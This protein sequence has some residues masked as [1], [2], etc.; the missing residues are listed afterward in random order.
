P[1]LSQ[2]VTAHMQSHLAGE[3][4]VNLDDPGDVHEVFA[5]LE[6]RRAEGIEVWP[7]LQPLCV[8]VAHHRYTASRGRDYVIILTEDLKKSLGKRPR[9]FRT[10]RVRHGLAAAC[11]LFGKVDIDAQTSQHSQSRKPDLRVHLIDVTRDEETHFGHRT[12]VTMNGVN[13][14]SASPNSC[15]QLRPSSSSFNQ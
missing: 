2:T 9:V 13:T 6:R 1:Q 8:V 4:T 7:P 3:V 12:L 10:A 5:E 11:L 14:R 15:Q